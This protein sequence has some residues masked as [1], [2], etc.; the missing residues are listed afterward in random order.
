MDPRVT[1]FL[2]T[3]ASSMHERFKSWE[4]LSESSDEK[5]ATKLD[6]LKGSNMS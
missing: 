4:L 2:A 3:W 6:E 1:N 5:P